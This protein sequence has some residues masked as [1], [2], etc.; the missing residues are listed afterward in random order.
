MLQL[1]RVFLFLA[2]A[3]TST[4]GFRNPS[5][6]RNRQH[7]VAL[8][9]SSVDVTTLSTETTWKLRFLL[10]GLP[11]EKG[12]RIDE[13][14]FTVQAQFVE[15]E[16]YEPPQGNLKQ[17]LTE[18]EEIGQLKIKSSRWILSEDPNERKDGLWVWGL[19]SDPLYPFMLLQLETERIQ[20][21]GEDGDAIKPLKLFCQLTHKREKG[22]GVIL[23]GSDLKVREMETIK[24]VSIVVVDSR[25]NKNMGPH[26]ILS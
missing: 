15:E 3:F 20:L 16:G 12:K 17:A 8:S 5:L 24:A 6:P 11:T 22:V 21:P 2:V 1:L 10:Q 18:E 26:P 19:F 14:L 4:Q 25:K 7:Q 23:K 9:A 13:R